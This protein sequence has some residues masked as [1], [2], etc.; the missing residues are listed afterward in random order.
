MTNDTQKTTTISPDPEPQNLTTRLMFEDSCKTVPWPALSQSLS[1]LLER[2]FIRLDEKLHA[3]GWD[4]LGEGR[5]RTGYFHKNANGVLKVSS[6]VAGVKANLT[7]LHYSKLGTKISVTLP[8][9]DYRVVTLPIPRVLG[10]RRVGLLSV[11]CVE[12]VQRVSYRAAKNLAQNHPWIDD[13]DED[14]DGPQVGYTNDGRLVCFD[15]C[16]F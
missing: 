2:D 13:V 15:W 12:R 8:W 1:G 7:E 10:H 5:H 11:L 6:N 4:L 14:E 3:K 9:A 16:N